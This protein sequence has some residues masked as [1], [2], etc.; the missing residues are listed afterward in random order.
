MR[1]LQGLVKE[2]VASVRVALRVGLVLLIAETGT[3]KSREL[4]SLVHT[5]FDT[6]AFFVY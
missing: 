4:N 6:A 3:G 5:Y 1:K 2:I